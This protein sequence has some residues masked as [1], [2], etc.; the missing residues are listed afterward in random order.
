MPLRRQFGKFRKFSPTSLRS[1]CRQCPLICVGLQT[2]NNLTPKPWR[3]WEGQWRTSGSSVGAAIFSKRPSLFLLKLLIK[4]KKKK[5]EKEKK[6]GGGGGG[7]QAPRCAGGVN[8]NSIRPSCKLSTWNAGIRLNHLA[9][10]QSTQSDR[11]LVGTNCKDAKL[12]TQRGTN[13][14]CSHWV[15]EHR[16]SFAA[17][18]GLCPFLWSRVLCKL[19]LLKAAAKSFLSMTFRSRRKQYSF[20]C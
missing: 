18:H 16:M 20:I 7:G 9:L 12:K 13:Y 5:K 11:K 1:V 19:G 15:S 10:H 4:N 8:S 2:A 6:R 17:R 14:Q 3:P